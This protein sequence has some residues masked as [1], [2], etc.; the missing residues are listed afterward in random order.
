MSPAS[1]KAITLIELLVVIG[2]IGVL[3][4]LLLPAIQAARG[5]ARRLQCQNNVRQLGIALHG[6]HSAM[7][8][9]PSGWEADSPRGEPGWGWA[10]YLLPYL[11]Q[12]NL[13]ASMT[14]AWPPGRAIGH[15]NNRRLRETPV[16]TYLCPSD[17]A[18]KIFTLHQ[19]GDGG[20]GAGPGQSA[21]A[22]VGNGPPPGAGPPMFRVARANYAGVFGR[23]VIENQP[24]FG[25][26]AFYHNSR[27][28]FASIR[29]GLS[30]TVIVGERSSRLGFPAW[31]GSVP[32]AHRSMA[33]VVA[34]GGR[35][36]NDVLGEFDDFSSYHPFG[37]NFLLADGSV[38]MIGDEISLPVYQA[39][40]T[41]S[42]GETVTLP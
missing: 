8:S 21:A 14:D 24:S 42:G 17:S 35:V 20:G 38:R 22:Q 2:I 19:R 18:P 9:L 13:A 15:P 1:R 7:R 10:T 39:L 37:A 26:G 16:G 33:R 29:D 6:H 30:N 40:V 32:G 3:I 27:L 34:R 28:R 41:R 23:N 31:I 36:P 25:D 11:E 5:A 12:Q 4:A